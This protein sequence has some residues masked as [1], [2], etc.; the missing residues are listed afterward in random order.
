MVVEN[1]RGLFCLI[2][3]VVWFNLS[4]FLIFVCWW[5]KFIEFLRKSLKYLFICCYVFLFCSFVVN[6]LLIFKLFKKEIINFEEFEI[7]LFFIGVLIGVLFVVIVLLLLLNGLLLLIVGV[8][9][10]GFFIGNI[11]MLFFFFLIVV[12]SCVSLF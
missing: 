10:I 4:W 2:L 11:G 6:F 12:D 9:I 3:K 7:W 8:L 5:I 1:L